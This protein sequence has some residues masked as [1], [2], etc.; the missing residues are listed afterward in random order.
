MK[1]EIIGT[2]YTDTVYKIKQEEK[3]TAETFE[4]TE[5]APNILSTFSND[6][7]GIV[8]YANTSIRYLSHTAPIPDYTI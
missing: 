4:E 3:T 1:W 5:R 2:K 8:Q 7:H 6:V